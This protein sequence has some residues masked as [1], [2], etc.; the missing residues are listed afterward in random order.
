MRIDNTV[1][2]KC[3]EKIIYTLRKDVDI[4]SIAH[5]SF[6]AEHLHPQLAEWRGSDFSYSSHLHS[7]LFE[8][9]ETEKPF[10]EY[11]FENLYNGM[12]KYSYCRRRNSRKCDLHF[13]TITNSYEGCELCSE[14]LDN[15]VK[16]KLTVC[17]NN[18][19]YSI[20]SEG[21]VT[22][23]THILD[24]ERIASK[25]KNGN[26]VDILNTILPQD[27]INKGTEMSEVYILLYCI[28]N[29][30]RIFIHK[31][32]RDKFGDNCLDEIKL[33][34]DL[35]NTIRNRKASEVKNNW[36]PV[37]GDN[38][39]FYLD[40]P[41]LGKVIQLNWDIFKNY[42]PDQTWILGKIDE[43]SECR[44][45]IAHNSYI[46]DDEKDLLSVDYKQ[47]LK[48]ISKAKS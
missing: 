43:I 31:C 5:L 6:L 32:C 26:T 9:Y 36:L 24:P 1:N 20:D 44:N 2:M 30:L 41:D 46:G 18:M 16:N 27:I 19:G 35:N 39:L 11:F 37:R 25:V 28:E 15:G 10:L 3:I 45:F 17:L 38:I 48:Q 47:I 23:G 40:L 14:F 42:F 8:I 22:S 12:N 34:T 21:F 33:T 13:S 29:S 4:V 7:F